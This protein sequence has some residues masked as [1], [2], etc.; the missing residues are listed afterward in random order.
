LVSV[1]VPTFRRAPI[2]AARGPQCFIQTLREWNWIVVVDGDDQET[3]EALDSITDPRL[4][5]KP[6][7]QKHRKARPARNVG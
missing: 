4:R 1:I 3:R 7:Q 2:G 5:V 6:L